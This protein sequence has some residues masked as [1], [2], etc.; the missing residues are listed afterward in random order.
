MSNCTAR[1]YVKTQG[2]LGST[3]QFLIA[4]RA[5]EWGVKA[6]IWATDIYSSDGL[7]ALHASDY[8][9]MAAQL[10]MIAFPELREA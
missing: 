8:A 7:T 10:A 2:R 6:D 5:A 3:N 1:E 4:Q 9:R